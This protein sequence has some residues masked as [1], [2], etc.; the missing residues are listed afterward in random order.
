MTFGD[1]C[2]VGGPSRKGS[3]VCTVVIEV[4]QS[5][6]GTTRILAVRDEDP[7][8][9]WDPPGEW[10]PAELPGVIGV[11]DRLANGA[12]LAASPAQGTLAVL[13]NRAPTPL[14]ADDATVLD[15][16]DA[17]PA[18]LPAPGTLRSRG[19]LVLDSMRGESVADHPG[20]ANFNLVET[21]GAGAWVTTWDGANLTR[22]ELSPGIHMIAHHEVDDLSSPRIERWLPEFKALENLPDDEWRA[23]WAAL[24]D[25][26]T[27]LHPDDDRAIIRDNHVHGF[28]TQS[29]LVVT[30][31]VGE[32]SA[33]LEHTILP[34]EL[35]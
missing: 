22:A 20:T 3:R 26:T 8:R 19:L 28:P 16:D 1:V 12:W 7:R 15:P 2:N 9:P 10:W 29:L 17:A 25:R 21:I 13:L 24:L 31:E 33:S 18:A 23:A 30:A 34:R 11:R 14:D 5:A 6:A 35:C 4:P 27:S 32:H